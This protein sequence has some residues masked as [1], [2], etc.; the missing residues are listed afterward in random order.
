MWKVFGL[1]GGQDWLPVTSRL[2]GS[3]ASGSCHGCV[4]TLHSRAPHLSPRT[5]HCGLE[6]LQEDLFS[7]EQ[8]KPL[9]GDLWREGFYGKG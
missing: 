4:C 8:L 1:C 3:W 2:A 6:D 9:W 5:G 7:K